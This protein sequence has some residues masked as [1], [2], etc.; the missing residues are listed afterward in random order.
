MCS[1]LKQLSKC[2]TPEDVISVLYSLKEYD[3]FLEREIIKVAVKL[4]KTSDEAHEVFHSEIFHQSN[5]YLVFEKMLGLIT[6]Q[7]ELNRLM[8]YFCDS[9]EFIF[10]SEKYVL[11][12]FKRRRELVE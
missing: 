11:Q 5:K 7:E 10:S 9:A 6:E 2:I 12:L 4:V 3:F 1:V 8:E